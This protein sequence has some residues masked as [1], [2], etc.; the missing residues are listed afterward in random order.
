[1]IRKPTSQCSHHADQPVRTS[2]KG[3]R[4]EEALSIYRRLVEQEP[5]AYL[6]DVARALTNLSDALANAGRYTDALVR[7]SS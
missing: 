1:M 3:R 4:L 7:P 5:A 6:L 2:W